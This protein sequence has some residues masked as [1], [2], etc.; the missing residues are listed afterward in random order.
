MKETDFDRQRNCRRGY[1][2]CSWIALAL[3]TL[4]L[5]GPTRLPGQT[6]CGTAGGAISTTAAS[7]SPGAMVSIPVTLTM[8]SGCSVDSLNF[9]VTV[10]AKGDAPPVTG[11]LD[12]VPASGLPSPT[13]T[14]GSGAPVIVVLIAGANPALGAGARALGTVSVP[15]PSNAQG[16]QT[17]TVNVSHSGGALDIKDVTLSAGPDATLTVTGVTRAAPLISASGIVNN[18]CYGACANPLAP[19]TIAA[20]FG[21]NLT[22]GTSCLHDAGC[23]QAF[24][25]NGR[26]KT[27]LT[28]A[29]VS[30]NG[31]PVPIY[32]S[33]PIQLGIQIP[34]D[35]TGAAAMVQVVVAGQSSP[36]STVSI[37]AV[38]PGI[39]ASGTGAGAITH[40]DG[41]AVS[42][43]NPAHPGELVILYATGLGQVTPSVP[44][45]ALPSGPNPSSTVVPTTVT[46]DG[47][48]VIP[49]FAGL[50]GCCVGLN[51]VSVRLPAST[52]SGNAI[53]VVLSI[54]G[55]QSNSV[56]LAVQ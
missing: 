15:I 45:G 56:T 9:T 17:Y 42:P 44:T 31:I 32:Y 34:T 38:S 23:D 16:G 11:A 21:T 39:F 26:L 47:I 6:N 46:I 7:G 53:P 48:A 2:C 19:G 35:L 12:F 33:S 25:N 29:Q 54:G 20:I 40:A 22:D 27:T 43:Q 55:K 41:S 18:A 8:N 51:Q 24:D 4:I 30:V 10:T 28:G 3:C 36:P 37:G 1:P 14:T 52:H 49:D 5:L 13:K 50:S